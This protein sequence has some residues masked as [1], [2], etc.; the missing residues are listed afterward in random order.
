METVCQTRRNV[1]GKRVALPSNVH[2]L[3]ERPLS[4]STLI[5]VWSWNVPQLGTNSISLSFPFFL[6]IFLPFF[7]RESSLFF[8]TNPCQV[9]FV[10][11]L[12]DILP[13]T[14]VARTTN[15]LFRLWSVRFSIAKART[16]ALP[17]L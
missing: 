11:R 12:R 8:S 3:G 6:R 16:K 14:F 4:Q 10:S 5:S 1:V 13:C 2:Y 7:Y 9:V 15:P 17:K